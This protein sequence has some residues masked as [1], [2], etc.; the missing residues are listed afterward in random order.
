[1]K[2]DEEQTAPTQYQFQKMTL[3]KWILIL[4]FCLLFNL[5]DS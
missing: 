3:G 5:E 1:M 2:Y 4:N